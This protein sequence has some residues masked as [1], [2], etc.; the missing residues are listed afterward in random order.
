VEG[1]VVGY[2]LAELVGVGVGVLVAVAV[3]DAVGEAV[4][5]AVAGVVEPAVWLAVVVAGALAGLLLDVAV[6][7]KM[8]G[9]GVGVGVGEDAEQAESATQ[10]RMTETPQ[11]TAVSRMPGT[12]PAIVLRAFMEPPDG[13]AGGEFVS[14]FQRRKRLR[15]RKVRGQHGRHQ[16]AMAC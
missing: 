5:V 7:V 16:D 12:V 10:A 4:T 6:D 8:A 15:N 1:A 2:A 14:R 11:P 3:A 13:P 9:V